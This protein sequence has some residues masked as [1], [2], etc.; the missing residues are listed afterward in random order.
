MLSAP[1]EFILELS[2][3]EQRISDTESGETFTVRVD[4]PLRIAPRSVV[5]LVGPSGCGKTTLLTVLGLLRSPSNP[6]SMDHFVMRTCHSDGSWVTHDLKECWAKGRRAQIESLRRQ[7]LGFALQSGELLP[8][9]TVRENIAAP[10]KLNGLPRREC[11]DRVTELMQSFGLEQTS[12]SAGRRS[13]GD[14]RVNR[15]SG[16]EYQRVA[17]AR[18]ISHRPILLFVDEP[19]SALNHEMAHGALSELRKLQRDKGSQGAAVMI[20]HDENLAL[21]FADVI[22][23]MAP[24]KGEAVGEVVDISDN[25]PLVDQLPPQSSFGTDAADQPSSV[26]GAPVQ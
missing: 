11:Q 7:Y 15:L 12:E 5:A 2:G 26:E 19:T 22:V 8:A 10:L 23:R 24:R 14:Q 4:C 21:T 1:P 3:L 20:T 13:L 9:L 6:D 25:L 16:G 18:A 17:L